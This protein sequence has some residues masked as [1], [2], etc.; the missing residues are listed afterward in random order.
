M[1]LNKL[2]T[3]DEAR[4][5]LEN[6]SA[7]EI[8]DRYKDKVLDK[9]K[10]AEYLRVTNTRNMKEGDD[11]KKFG[12]FENVSKGELSA[13]IVRFLAEVNENIGFV[14]NSLLDDLP[15]EV[16][17]A[18]V[19]YFQELNGLTV[20]GIIGNETL[21]KAR[22]LLDVRHVSWQK[23]NKEKDQLVAESKDMRKELMTEI[24]P[25]V[26]GRII[27][28]DEIRSHN[29]RLANKSQNR[30]VENKIPKLIDKYQAIVDKGTPEARAIA[31]R[32]MAKLEALEKTLK[33]QDVAEGFK[34][35]KVTL[36]DVALL[37]DLEIPEDLENFE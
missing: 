20:D 34:D 10:A 3:N 21:S 35:G 24:L 11:F 30:R 2:E 1:G 4:K 31:E 15:T 26:K 27:S 17:L 5:G 32:E 12:L 18:Y 28:I 25:G 23:L 14:E 19:A 37:M 33:S 8:I 16:A 7:D 6:L 36:S 13:E 22:K 29:L 9:G